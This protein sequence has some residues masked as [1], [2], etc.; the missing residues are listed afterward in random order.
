M[1]VRGQGGQLEK[2]VECR[3]RHVPGHLGARGNALGRPDLDV[4][5]ELHRRAGD[6]TFQLQT[7]RCGGPRLLRDDARVAD[8]RDGGIAVDDHEGDAVGLGGHARKGT[9]H[10][11]GGGKGFEEGFEHGSKVLCCENSSGSVRALLS[12]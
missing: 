7:G 5:G 6:G 11:R 3:S 1:L 8:R 10:D 12:D 4:V 2:P 9:G